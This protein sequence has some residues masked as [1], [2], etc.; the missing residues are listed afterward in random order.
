MRSILLLIAGAII[1]GIG[2][3]LYASYTRFHE[4]IGLAVALKA[5]IESVLA[6]VEMRRYLTLF[7]LWVDHL[8]AAVGLINHEHIISARIDQDYFGVFHSAREKIGLLGDASAPIV[9]AY[10]FAKAFMEDVRDLTEVR[11]HPPPAGVDAQ[12]LAPKVRGA[13]A[14]LAMAIDA[15]NQAKTELRGLS[16]QRWWLLSFVQ[17]KAVSDEH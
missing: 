14:A 16:Q 7:N 1:G 17:K 12:W 9:K 3:I 15:A 10:T 5:E 8:E 2:Q 4:K 11:D 13:R 6:I